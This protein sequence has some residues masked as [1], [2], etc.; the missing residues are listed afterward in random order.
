MLRRELR[1]K[2]QRDAGRP[3]DGLIFVPDQPGQ[4]AE[5]VI[6]AD[7]DLVMLGT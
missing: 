7:G 5:K 2:V 6:D 1:D 3:G 4:G